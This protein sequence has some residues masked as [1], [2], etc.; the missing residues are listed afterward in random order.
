MRL[1]SFAAAAILLVAGPALADAVTYSGTLGKLPIIVELSSPAEEGGTL[2]GRYAYMSKG[3]DIPLASV[4]GPKG[5]LVLD[6]EAP[7]TVKLCGDP[8]N[9]DDIKTPVGARWTLKPAADGNG[10][11]G[12]WKDKASGKS[13]PIALERQATRAVDVTNNSLL[14]SLS[15]DY[16]IVEYGDPKVVSTDDMPYDFLKMDWPLQKG[17][18]TRLGDIAYRMDI[19]TRV[20]LSYPVVTALGDTDVEPVNAYLA[21]QRLQYELASFSCLSR[22]Y[23]GYSWNGGESQGS[24]G[25]GDGDATVTVDHIS[26]RL[27]GLA[28]AG[29]YWCGG[30]HPDNYLERRLAD[31]ET[32]EALLPES[33]MRGWVITGE[34][35]EV[36]DPAKADE[37]D[38]VLTYTPGDDIVAY[39]REHRRKFDA[40][41]ESECGLDELIAS[42]LAVY[43]QQDNLVFTLKGLPYVNF[44][45]GEDLLEVPLKDARPLLTEAAARYFE[46]LDE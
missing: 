4:A 29:S 23:A 24:N 32:G 31:A 3:A 33:L 18:E 19:D 38:D 25:F 35:G 8:N 46:A 16:S 10:I 36:I 9:G 43:F 17:E 14:D 45:C 2:A 28:E 39:V 44:A 26:P 34:S 15:P 1:P 22:A 11:T 21:Q 40:E 7:C 13:L 41:T 5:T 12:T 27:I 30:A 6:E 37:V 42:N 20:G